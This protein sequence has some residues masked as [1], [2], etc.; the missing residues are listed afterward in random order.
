MEV[1]DEIVKTVSNAIKILEAD[2]FVEDD[3][4]EG[5]AQMIG[6]IYQSVGTDGSVFTDLYKKLLLGKKKEDASSAL[7]LAVQHMILFKQESE[8]REWEKKQM[9]FHFRSKLAYYV[10]R[11]KIRDWHDKHGYEGEDCRRF[12]GRGV[13]YSAIT[14]GYDDVREPEYVNSQ[15]DYILFTDNPQ[16]T[17]EVW[18]VVLLKNEDGLDNVR[19]A[20]KVKILGH[21][22]LPEYDYSIWVDGCLKITGDLGEYIETYRGSEPML[23]FNHHKRDCAYQEHEACAISNKDD[24]EIME[25]QMNRYR[26]E[27]Y[28]ENNGLVE[29]GVLVR[30]LR[31]KRVKQV[32]ETWWSE[33]LNGSKRDQLSFGYACWKNDFVFDTSDLVIYFNKFTQICI[34]K[35]LK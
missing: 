34:H 3:L 16:I 25:K 10:N 6:M 13:V 9:T 22:Y 27:G 12:Q 18:K 8:S 28:P 7:R 5:I 1:Y 32:M 15:L 29:S 24:P 23:C 4:L 35:E 30:E 20:R 11:E 31:N 19:L 17:S 33:I 2:G 21:E 26:R 14:G